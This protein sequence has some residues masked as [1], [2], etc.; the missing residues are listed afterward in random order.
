M[1]YK[2]HKVVVIGAGTM[3]GGIAA[4]LANAGVRVTLA[5]YR[6]E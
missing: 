4:L 5:G 1:K 2:I 6:S 3:G